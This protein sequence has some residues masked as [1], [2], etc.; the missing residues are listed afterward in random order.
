MA[1]PQLADLDLVRLHGVT[2]VT[3]VHHGDDDLLAHDELVLQ[4]G[5]RVHVVGP[6]DEMA[7]VATKLFGDSERQL[8]EV[9]PVGFSLGIT[10]GLL[11]GSGDVPLPGGVK[12]E[13][14]TGGGPLLVR[15]GARLRVPHWPGHLADRTWRQS[16]P[17]PFQDDLMF[18]ACAGLGLRHGV[19]RGGGDASRPRARARR[20]RDRSAVRR[21]DPARRRGCSRTATCSTPPECSPASRPARR[22]R[23]HRRALVGD[24]RV[25]RAY[26]LVFP[27]AI[28]A[29]IIIVQFLA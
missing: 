16:G 15:L 13:L 6:T 17:P 9:D 29:K 19:R 4:L 26:A 20:S 2:T 21:R 18:L 8:P 12:L 27:V 3:R 22:A 14:G 11:I 28:I 25:N 23:L 5:D 7:A 24:E 10:A 1:E